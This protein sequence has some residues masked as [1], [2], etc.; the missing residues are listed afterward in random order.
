MLHWVLTGNVARLS[1]T[2]IIVGARGVDVETQSCET[3]GGNR[4]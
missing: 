1:D 3:S 4:P 2:I